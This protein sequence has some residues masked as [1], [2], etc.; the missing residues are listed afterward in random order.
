[1]KRRKP[2]RAVARRRRHGLGDGRRPARA[3]VM[4]PPQAPPRAACVSTSK[5]S[6]RLPLSAA[7]GCPR[8]SPRPAAICGEE[9][10][11]QVNSKHPFGRRL[12]LSVGVLPPTKKTQGLLTLGLVD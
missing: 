10:P 1:M 7:G 2:R 11:V 4:P 5:G 6:C 12:G 9:A 8:R 3:P